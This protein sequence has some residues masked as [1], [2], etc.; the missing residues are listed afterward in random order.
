M[1]QPHSP[2]NMLDTTA[3]EEFLIDTNIDKGFHNEAASTHLP[4]FRFKL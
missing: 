2:G 4:L 3:I 1:P